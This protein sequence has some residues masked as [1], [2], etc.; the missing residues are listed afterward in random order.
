MCSSKAKP[1]SLLFSQGNTTMKW[2]S[3]GVLQLSRLFQGG[4]LF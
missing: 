2:N 3:Y 1:S 4:R